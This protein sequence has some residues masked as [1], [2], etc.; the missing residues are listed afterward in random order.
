MNEEDA[1]PGNGADSHGLI[2]RSV[3]P[4]AWRALEREM[5]F[6]DF[7]DLFDVD[8]FRLEGQ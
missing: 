3:D 4:D 6:P 2:E 7:L 1:G 8:Q 5:L